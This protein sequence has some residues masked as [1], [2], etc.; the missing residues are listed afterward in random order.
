LDQA[1]SVTVDQPKYVVQIEKLLQVKQVG[2]IKDQ[3]KK[4]SE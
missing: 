3:G 2:R 4:S 1:T